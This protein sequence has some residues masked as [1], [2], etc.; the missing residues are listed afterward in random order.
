MISGTRR[1][2]WCAFFLLGCVLPRGAEK[3]WSEEET[4]AAEAEAEEAATED[5]DEGDEAVEEDRSPLTRDQFMHDLERFLGTVEWPEKNA[6]ESLAVA[7]EQRYAGRLP[8]AALER[9]CTHAD[10]IAALYRARVDLV[11]RADELDEKVKDL[12]KNL[13]TVK[14]KGG[15]RKSVSG[16]KKSAGFDYRNPGKGSVTQRGPR[17]V[18]RKV[19]KGVKKKA[20]AMRDQEESVR[21]SGKVAEEAYDDLI[22]ALTRN[23]EPLSAENGLGDVLELVAHSN[24]DQVVAVVAARQVDVTPVLDRSGNTALHVAAEAGNGAAI[25]SL[26]KLGADIDALNGSKQTA[27][28]VAASEGNT[29]AAKA[30]LAAGADKELKDRRNRTPYTWAIR[31]NNDDTAKA[32]DP[33]AWAADHADKDE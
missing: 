10:W 4:A 29:G 22:K 33:E 14:V 11:D 7:L 18:V 5:G 21:A 13:Y 12:R 27:L 17:Q 1:W 32:I 28:H 30:L 6:A 20:E 2:A 26:L 9:V 8:D 31:T 25:K 24:H 19:N 23:T 15:G 3:A 16:Y